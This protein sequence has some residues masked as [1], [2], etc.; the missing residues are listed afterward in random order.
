MS[1]S[2][3][4]L[5]EAKKFETQLLNLKKVKISQMRN[6]GKVLRIKLAKLKAEIGDRMAG[7]LK[8]WVRWKEGDLHQ[9]RV[10]Q[11]GTMMAER[12]EADLKVSE[13]EGSG[14]NIP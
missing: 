10:G 8:S 14:Q 1:N 13:N 11:L 6:L 4:F 3:A 2:S 5:S 9:I 7:E 12:H